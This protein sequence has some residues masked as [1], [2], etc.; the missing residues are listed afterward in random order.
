MLSFFRSMLNSKIGA[1]VA[2]LVLVLIAL[3]FA[4]GDI[5]GL[6]GTSVDGGTAVAVVGGEKIDAN[7]LEQGAKRS[8]ERVKQ[9]SPTATMKI[10]VEQ[11]GLEQVLDDLIGR[12][13]LFAFGKQNKIVVS[14]RLI[15][16]ELTQ[17]PGFQGVDGKFDQ[18]TYR[19]VL[20]RQGISEQ[21]LRDDIRQNLTAQ[22]L[23]SA[24]QFGTVLPTY[25]A[26][27]YATLLD[28][29]RSG[30]VIALP[31]LLFAPQT[32]P[33]DAQLAAFYKS[34]LSRFIRPERRVVRYAQFGEDVL[35]N[36]PAPTDAEI[37]KRFDTDKALYAAQD[38]RKITQ[39]IV[40]TEAAA[41]AIVAEISGGKSLEMAAS[42]KGLSAAKLEFM[43]REQLSSQFS[44]GVADAVFAASTGKLAAPQKSPLGWHVIRV[45]E[46]Q[47]KPARTLAEVRTDIAATLTTEKRRTAFTDLLAKIEDQFGD[48][49]NLG[50]VA[51]ALGVAVETTPPITADGGI[52]QQP[53]QSV[54][55]VLKPVLQTAFSMEQEEPQVAEVERGKTFVV[56]DVSDVAPSAPAPLAQIRN[57]VK[58]AWMLDAGAQA[59]RAAAVRL[60]AEIRKG[61]S[62]E[63]AIAGVGRKLPPVQQVG[64][65]RATLTAAMRAGR[66]IPPPVALMFKMA[67]GTVKVQSAEGERG[68]FVVQ[69]KD[70]ATGTVQAPQ[71]VAATRSELGPQMGEVY[72]AALQEAVKKDVGVKRNEAAIKSVRDQLAGTAPAN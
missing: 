13:A 14:D 28:E 10:L 57:D 64:M 12:A 36:V 50:E 51:K 67:K 34:H 24:A 44:P 6:R 22:Q 66:Q 47:K 70:I 62:I 17:I 29:T 56:F 32:Q 43:S 3:A 23:V 1:A 19:Q 40:P 15:D 61:R 25:V 60:Q 55:D 11:G 20:A 30:S 21:A 33:S 49:A 39:L 72:A 41:K 68:W 7:V 38:N 4:S 26:T 48:G 63:Q 54:P 58:F 37:A 65:S 5:A 53:G 52:Y 45:D 31:S 16:S 59:A 9:Q 46:E 69:L 2:L 18:N 71:L 8:L 27:R 42:E 35:K